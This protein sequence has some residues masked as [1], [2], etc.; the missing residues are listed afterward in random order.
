MPTGG[1]LLKFPFLF[2]LVQES[3]L[4]KN[5]KRERKTFYTVKGKG[6]IWLSSS[7]RIIIFLLSR[8]LSNK[9]QIGKNGVNV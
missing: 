5:K 7:Y 4:K 9:P 6:L 3:G 2:K 8:L 1:N